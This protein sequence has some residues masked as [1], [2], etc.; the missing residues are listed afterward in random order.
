MKKIFTHSR[1]YIY[2]S[3][4]AVMFLLSYWFQVLYS[5]AWILV[6]VF[7]VLVI[8]DLLILFRLKNGV[9]A[10]RK[11]PIKLSNADANPIPVS[12]KNNYP[13]R[14]KVTVIDEIPF[15]F[16][17]RNFNYIINLEQGEN[18]KFE[19][20]LRPVDRGEYYFG[21]LLVFVSSPL[22]I[23]IKRYVFCDENKL[24]KVYPSYI[25][26]KKYEFLALN[27]RLYEYGLKKIRR[28]GHTMEFE[29]I[30]KYVPGD[31]IRTINWK[32]TAKHAKLMVN[33][34]Q[35]EKSQPIYSL[36]DT[37]RIM[38]MP[39]EGLKLLDYAINSVLAF[40]NIILLKKDKAGLIEFGKKVEHFLLASNVKSR[41]SIINETLYNIDS[42]FVDS[43]FSYLYTFVRRNISQ[44]SLLILYTNFEHK[45][46]L[47]RQMIYLKALAKKHLLVVI[48]FENTELDELVS[49]KVED[50]QGVYHKT[51]AEKFV[52]DKR[53]IVKELQLNGIHT[54]L[55]KPENL[56]VN[57]INM[58]LEFKSRGRI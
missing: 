36:I 16:Q 8:V 26:M 31:D 17:K 54:I 44:R 18:Y 20:S 1:L 3:V 4:I 24:V 14:I 56:T 19:Y 50:L 46:S 48:I 37:G 52:Y 15:Q 21:N 40:S 39:F 34:Y 6:A 9:V 35:D 32:T 27:N 30:K 45:S 7:I 38:K 47:K 13:F 42:D 10:E 49:K 43:D 57:V 53:L 22:R 51:I 12:I 41:L 29:Q 55:T 5:A 25:Q 2:L 33:E 23:F 11:L 28:L 58:Y